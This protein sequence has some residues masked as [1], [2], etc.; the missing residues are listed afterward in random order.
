MIIAGPWHRCTEP[1]IKSRQILLA[2]ARDSLEILKH[3]LLLVRQGQRPFYRVA[4][5][6]LR[7]LLCDTTRRHNQV[8]DIAM[9]P[10][11][12]PDLDLPAIGPGGI[13]L[14][15]NDWLAQ[16]IPD[17][18]DQSFT[19]RQIIRRVCDQDGGAHVDFK[20]EA[21]LDGLDPAEWIQ[22]IGEIV[23]DS[24]EL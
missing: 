11:L 19:V 3:S 24:I 20:P 10:Q 2:Y 23:V 21:G 17:H 16:P 15:L 1:V 8:V 4:A 14:P 5:V 22:E 7:L 12:I 18:P 9:L 13:R 6:Q